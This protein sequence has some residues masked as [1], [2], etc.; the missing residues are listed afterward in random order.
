MNTKHK[1]KKKRQKRLK[2]AKHQRSI[3]EAY[4][5][6]YPNIYV[7]NHYASIELVE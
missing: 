1:K 5:K 3:K 4:L 2:A 6:R 7:Y